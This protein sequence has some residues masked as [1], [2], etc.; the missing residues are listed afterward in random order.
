MS[1][2][3]DDSFVIERGAGCSPLDKFYINLSV[4]Q[5]TLFPAISSPSQS[6]VKHMGD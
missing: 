5:E 2:K 1:K 3:G 4:A 6:K